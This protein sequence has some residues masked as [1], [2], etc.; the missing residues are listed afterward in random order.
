[1]ATKL[2]VKKGDEVYVLTG[3]DR[4]K[5][6]KVLEVHT[7]TQRVTVAGVNIVKKHRKPRPP[8]EPEGGIKE[9]P[10]SI[11]VSN[12]KLVTKDKKAKAK[13]SAKAETK[14]KAKKSEAK[15]EVKKTETKAEVKKSEAKAEPKKAEAKAEAKK[16]DAKPAKKATKKASKA[17]KKATKKKDD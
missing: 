16:A 9:V 4:G 3:K 10:A 12:V 13:T 6:G 1:M 15:A 11:H 5:S 17:K 7:K 8:A 14:T 2:H